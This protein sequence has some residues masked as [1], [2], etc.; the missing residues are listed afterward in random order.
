MRDIIAH[1]V[2][3]MGLDEK[4]RLVDELRAAIAE[5]LAGGSGE[6]AECPRCGCATFVGKGRGRRGER[7]WLC[8]G[9]GRTFSAGTGSVLARSRLDAGTWARFASC[10][11][12]R[13]SLRETAAELGVC[14]LC[15]IA[16]RLRVGVL[17]IIRTRR[18]LEDPSCIARSRRG[19]RSSS[20]CDTTRAARR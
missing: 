19:A 12:A 5:D 3:T 20:T 15:L 9:C 6:P 1:E 7:R 4:R 13:L 2:E 17:T 8:R 14:L 10:M 11:V 18:C 16:S